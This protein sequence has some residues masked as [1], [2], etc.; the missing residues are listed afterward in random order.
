MWRNGC[1]RT[2]RQGW[3]RIRLLHELRRRLLL[4]VLHRLQLRKML[5]MRVCV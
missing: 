4:R 1:H 5:C 2:V 3:R